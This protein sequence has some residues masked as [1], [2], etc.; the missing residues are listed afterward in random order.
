MVQNFF[1][2]FISSMFW[3]TYIP[4]Y[5]RLF[6]IFDTTEADALES[7]LSTNI[8]QRNDDDDDVKVNDYDN[9]KNNR[10]HE[11]FHFHNYEFSQDNDYYKMSEDPQSNDI[12]HEYFLSRQPRTADVA[13]FNVTFIYYGVYSPSGVAIQLVQNFFNWFSTTMFW[14]SYTPFYKRL[15]PI[16]APANNQRSLEVEESV[17]NPAPY[18]KYLLLSVKPGTNLIKLTVM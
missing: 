11:T 10:H 9:D 15:L 3:L 12:S 2:F 13:Q 16:F 8:D 1:N 7:Q 5:E 4:V 18:L 6:P 17:I 14:L